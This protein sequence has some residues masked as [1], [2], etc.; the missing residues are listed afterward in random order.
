MKT[1][2]VKIETA[3]SPAELTLYLHGKASEKRDMIMVIPGGA[4]A[5]IAPLEGEPVCREFYRRGFNTACLTYSVAPAVFPCALAQAALSLAHLRDNAQ[6][7]NINP[8]RIFIN[9]YSAGGHLAASLGTLWHTPIAESA[10]GRQANDIKPNG[11]ILGYP[12]ISSGEFA[13]ADSIKNL[14]G[15]NYGDEKLMELVSLEK[16]VSEKTVPTF[17]WATATDNA[18][19]VEN[20][21]LFTDMLQK[22]GVFYESLIFSHGK[23]GMCLGTKE[24][25]PVKYYGP[26]DYCPD[27]RIWVDRA[28]DFVK[29]I[30]D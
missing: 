19:P 30:S 5:G 8:Q 4:Y 11:M 18:V 13:H 9:G 1:L 3:F 7:Y 21:M 26:E 24:T 17:I 25:F 12:V 6:E 20:T 10:S 16:Q 23:H 27:L 28:V 29:R 15:E 2:T 22:Y 14:L